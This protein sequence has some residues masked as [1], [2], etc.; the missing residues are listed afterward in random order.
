[1]PLPSIFLGVTVKQWVVLVT[2]GCAAAYLF[3]FQS[4][5]TPENLAL[6]AFIRSQE[7][8]AEQVGAVLDVAL[9]RQVVA[10][11]GYNTAGYQRSMFTVEG[12]RGRLL[13]TLKQVEGE[14]DIEV[15]QIRRP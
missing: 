9:V 12:E 10:H 5:T 1:M 15:T 14:Q 11:P 4:E 3:N 2:I 7:Q 13:V 8:V 6:E